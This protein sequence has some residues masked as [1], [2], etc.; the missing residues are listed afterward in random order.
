M[1]VPI[2]NCCQTLSELV[3][4]C[5]RLMAEFPL[6]RPDESFHPSVL[7]GHPS[8]MRCWMMHRFKARISPTGLKLSPL[9]AFVRISD[10]PN[11]HPCSSGFSS[12][13]I[14][15][16][17]GDSRSSLQQGREIKKQEGGQ[18]HCRW[19]ETSL[20]SKTSCEIRRHVGP[21]AGGL[22]ISEQVARID[23]T[24]NGF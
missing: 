24:N 21:K 10:P 17:P 8:S 16:K 11:S 1:V 23:W 12:D 7:P 9:V 2:T 20:H 5:H 19:C 4:A 15:T 18:H 3:T 14:D 13:S 22:T 6:H